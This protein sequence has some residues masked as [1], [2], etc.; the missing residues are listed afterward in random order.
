MLQS[1][2]E[3]KLIAREIQPTAMRIL[4]L[5]ELSKSKSA[6]SLL[7]LE[8]HF[9]AADRSTLFRTLKT[10]EKNKLVHSIDDGSGAIK[11]ALC[12]E[13]CDCLPEQKH[14]H[15]HCTKCNSTYCINEV[16]FPKISLPK[17]FVGQEINLVVK[18]LCDQCS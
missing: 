17:N 6:L 1:E 12:E 2:L 7:E 10:F 16:E 5:D 18:G 4:V 11:Y 14:M 15:F 3:Q 9:D 13:N 8:S